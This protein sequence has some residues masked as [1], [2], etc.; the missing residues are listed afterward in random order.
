MSELLWDL[1][2]LIGIVGFAF[3]PVATAIAIL[4]Y[5]LYNIDRFINRT[6]V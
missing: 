2:W 3:L 6:L 1:G 4:K 5:R